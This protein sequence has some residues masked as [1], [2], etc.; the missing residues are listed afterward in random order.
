MLDSQYRLVGLSRSP[1]RARQRPGGKAYQWRQ[2]DLFSRRQT[3]DALRDADVAVYLVHSL[4]PSARLTQ[5][6]VGDLDVL[7]ADNFARAAAAADVDHIVYVSP[8]L[9]DHDSPSPFIASR[10]EVEAA[11]RSQ[12]TTVTALRATQ[13][14]G[15]GSTGTEMICRLVERL[16]AMLLPAW[17]DTALRPL[18]RC[19]LVQ[20]I[21]DLI[22]RPDLDIDALNIGGPETSSF[23]SMIATVADLMDRRCRLHSAPVDAPRLSTAW[24]SLWTGQP[25]WV[26]RPLI[27]SLRRQGLQHHQP[28]PEPL[29]TPSTSVRQAFQQALSERDQHDTSTLPAVVNNRS[30]I[31]WNR[32]R[33]VRAVHRM[34]LPSDQ[35]HD[36]SW[37]A[38]EY[39]RWL[40]LAFRPFLKVTRDAS[41]TLRFFLRP[42]PWP[43]LVLSYDE[44]VSRTDRQLYWI[45][46]GLLARPSDTGRLEF[47][48]VLSGRSAIG[49]I[50]DFRPRLPWFLYL[51]T[52]A[53]IHHLV[54]RAFDRHLRRIDS[55]DDSS[56]PPK[57]LESS[58]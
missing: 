29:T 37:V 38:L 56:P 55:S 30:L 34:K 20:L 4:Y 57:A 36:A 24:I 41:N 1:S 40:P 5:G 19:D 10:V 28:L 11:L 22:P 7:C 23:R 46:A 42:I 2:A 33:D 9:P 54:M 21:A 27:E 14:I 48:T 26:I 52:Q 13:I 35:T 8:L 25:R 39:A 17:N 45:T 31:A 6:R 47:R 50:H 15:A 43:L 44:D 32:N 49:A 58:P 18:A 12:G 16:P 51:L 53:K 3:I